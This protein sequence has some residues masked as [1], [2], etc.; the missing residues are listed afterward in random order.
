MQLA[1]RCYSLSLHVDFVHTIIFQQN[2]CYFVIPSIYD[3]L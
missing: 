1:P 3:V 2:V